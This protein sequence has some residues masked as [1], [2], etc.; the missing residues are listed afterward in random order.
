MYTNLVVRA[1]SC[2]PCQSRVVVTLFIYRIAKRGNILPSTISA[3]TGA[4]P[5]LQ[6]ES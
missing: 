6:I 2:Q 5:L 1:Y 4:A 3:A